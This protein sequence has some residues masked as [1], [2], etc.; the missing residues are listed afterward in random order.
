MG[1][2]LICA[3]SIFTSFAKYN[4]GT[5][6]ILLSA[7]SYKQLL[8]LFKMHSTETELMFKRVAGKNQFLSFD[9]FLRVLKEIATK[10]FITSG[11]WFVE[12][13]E[14]ISPP[15]KRLVGEMMRE[16]AYCM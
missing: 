14:E 8:K 10:R 16:D 15:V 3:K 6:R 11:K 5:R 1:D 4:E 7:F 9:D 2:E 12:E 13:L